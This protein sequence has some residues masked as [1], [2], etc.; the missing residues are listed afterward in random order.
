MLFAPDQSLIFGQRTGFA[1]GNGGRLLDD[2][3]EIACRRLVAV[4]QY[5]AHLNIHVAVPHE[6]R[7][8]IGD[9]V[10]GHGAGTARPQNAFHHGRRQGARADR[11][12]VA[13]ACLVGKHLL[14]IRP[15]PRRSLD[16][17][18]KLLGPRMLTPRA[19]N[20]PILV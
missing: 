15:P 6:A 5:L 12:E 7:T 4:R 19:Q 3:I 20:S 18:M 17:H 9:A 2:R 13:D 16:L 14:A 11:G 8:E 1:A 10:I